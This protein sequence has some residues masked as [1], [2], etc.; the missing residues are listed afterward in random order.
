VLFNDAPNAL[1]AGLQGQRRV[2]FLRDRLNAA[3]GLA[4]GRARREIERDR[5]RGELSLVVD[6]ERGD[7]HDRIDQRR[8]GHLLAAR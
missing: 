5:H 8:Q 4:N 2:Q 6:D 3:D 7:L 1:E